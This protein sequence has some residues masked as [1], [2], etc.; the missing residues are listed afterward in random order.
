MIVAEPTGL[1]RQTF[2]LTDTEGSGDPFGELALRLFRGGRLTIGD[3]DYEI[4]AVGL[5]QQGLDL[6]LGAAHIAAAR[7]PS[8]FRRASVVTFAAEAV[9]TDADLTVDLTPEGWFGRRWA[10]AA[11]GLDVGRANWTGHIRSR[12][13]LD[14]PD[15]LPLVARAFIVAVLAI[16]R[17]NDRNNG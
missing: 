9:G 5:L 15:A 11:D 17:R 7:R 10:V 4:A 13:H 16:Q 3:A 2:T 6:T 8:L 14:V 12:L 1:L